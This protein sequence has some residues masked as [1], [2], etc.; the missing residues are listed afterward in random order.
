MGRI[1]PLR[2]VAALLVFIVAW[3]TGLSKALLSLPLKLAGALWQLRFPAVEPDT[4]S[5]TA[6]II[7]ITTDSK[8]TCKLIEEFMH[9]P[10]IDPQVEVHFRSFLARQRSRSFPRLEQSL[11]WL[12]RVYWVIL[13]AVVFSMLCNMM[14]R[15][16][17]GAA[18][19]GE[20]SAGTSPLHPGNMATSSAP[21]VRRT[22]S[23]RRGSHPDALVIAPQ[24][25]RPTSSGGFPKAGHTD[26]LLQGSDIG[27]AS[28]SR[29]M[30]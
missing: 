24:L 16:T 21:N 19:S 10:G 25:S 1:T 2:L 15:R 22:R 27:R 29:K 6:A 3:R 18:D 23:V 11:E 9:S 12:L 5:L 14:S 28:P 8:Q 17:A 30:F 13:P 4:D 7:N 26:P 20:D